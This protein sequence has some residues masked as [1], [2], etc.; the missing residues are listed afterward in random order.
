MPR[1]SASKKQRGGSLASN[2]V[3]ENLDTVAATH[4]YVVSP[5]IRTKSR[6]GNTNTYQLTGGD[7]GAF[8]FSGL[9]ALVLDAGVG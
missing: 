4:D 6:F 8:C 5:R 9:A 1:K 3:M 7:C 2:R